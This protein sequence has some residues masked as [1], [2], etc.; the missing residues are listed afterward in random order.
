MGLEQEDIIQR[1]NFRKKV[2]KFKVFQ[3]KKEKTGTAWSEEKKITTARG[4]SLN[5]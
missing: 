4:N 1:N 3:R 2:K 5:S